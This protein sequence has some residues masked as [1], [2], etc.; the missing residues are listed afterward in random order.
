MVVVGS[1]KEAVRWKLAIDQYIKKQGYPL[2][3]LVAFS[4][5]VND[6]EIGPDGFTEPSRSLNPGL[7]GD[8]R[9]AFKGT[10]YQILLVA[11]KFQTGFDQPLLC[12]M[13]V[14]RRLDGIQA[15][16][17]LSRL[18]RCHL[19]KHTTYVVDFV[20]EPNEILA[21]FKTYYATAEL[22]EA[23]DPNLI[24][25]LKTKL[26][27]QG[28]YDEFKI[29]RVMKVLLEDNHSDKVRQKHLFGAFEPVAQRLMTLHKEAR[30]A[31]SQAEEI[32]DGEAVKHAKDELDALTL[33]RSDI[34]TYRRS[35]AWP[36]VVVA[37]RTKTRWSWRR[38]SPSS[39]ICSLAS[40]ATATRSPMC[41]P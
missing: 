8:I 31:Y 30:L 41:L 36:Q 22:A 34:G 17:T 39:M 15:V 7:K 18:N 6:P 23:T 21:A 20:N 27:A 28:H 11:N 12:G 5:E 4:G 2:G 1:P 37:C 16:Q 9:E 24:L 10:D 33:F 38:S 25:D 19:G 13:Y 29:D 40:S 32:N 35:Q 14:D 3:T 26:D